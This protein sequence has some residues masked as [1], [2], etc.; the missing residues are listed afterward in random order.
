SMR[1][2]SISSRFKVPSS[3]FP[4]LNLELGT[5]NPSSFLSFQKQFGFQYEGPLVYDPFAGFEAGEDFDPGGG[6]QSRFDVGAAE[7]VFFFRNEDEGLSFVPHYGPWGN[8]E[9]LFAIGERNFDPDEHA[10][11]E[12]ALTVVDIRDQRH[13]V[14]VGGN[15][16]SHV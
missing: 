13:G 8:D 15:L 5:L 12:A 16:A 3:R 4:T 2:V 10:R 1:A 11:L 7:R 9:R 14:R 6:F